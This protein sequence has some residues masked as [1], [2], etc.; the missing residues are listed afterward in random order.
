MT[1]LQ[2]AA[3]K[4]GYNEQGFIVKHAAVSKENGSVMF[5]NNKVGVE[6]QG[7]D[8][9]CTGTGDCVNVPVYSLDT[10]VEKFVPEGRSINHLSVDVEGYDYQVLLGGNKTLRRVHYLEF[11]YNWM[12]PW[13]TQPLS[14][15]IEYLDKEFGFVCYWPGFDNTIW[16]ITNCWLDHY[17]IHFWS[18]VACVNRNFAE[19]NEIAENMESMFLDT[20][21]RGG[22]AVRDFEHRFHN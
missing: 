9:G 5:Q 14:E 13:K 17:N 3:N 12:G 6:N 8:N 10:Y 2:Q 16:R 4:T 18:N 19:A 7:L 11:E 1:A 21:K 20:L 15:A 22:D